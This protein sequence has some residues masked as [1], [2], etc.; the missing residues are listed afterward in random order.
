MLK[1]LEQSGFV[2]LD[3]AATSLTPQPVIDAMQRYYTEQRVTIHRGAYPQAREVAEAYEAVRSRTAAFIGASSASE[4][5]FT[6]SA[7]EALNL[8]AWG[9]AAQHVRSGDEIL[10]SVMEHHANFVPWQ[11]LAR[12]TGAVVNIVPLDPE[13]AGLDMN[14]LRALLSG[15]VRL[16]AVTG[17]SNVTGASPPLAEIADLVHDVGAV[18]VVDGT[19]M[20]AHQEVRLRDLNCDFL[21]FSGHKLCGPTGVGVLYGRSE[22][23]EAM[24]PLNYGG[25]MILSV[26]E[27][28]SVLLD[29]PRRFEGGTPNIAG[30]LGFGEA[31]EFLG[32]LGIHKIRMHESDLSERLLRACAASSSIEIINRDDSSS[33]G[34]ILSF[35]PRRDSPQELLGRLE[36]AG[37]MLRSGKLCAHPL[38]RSLGHSTVLRVSF[39]P[40]TSPQELAV[41]IDLV[42]A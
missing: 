14:A 1:K 31:L 12:R 3:S 38:I 35:V 29:P 32:S 18:L 16:V 28:R 22:L 6:K 7:T 39:G 15:N 30:V 23:L 5:V 11:Q 19:Q 20:V 4:I 27:K 42:G 33:P 2:Y 40:Y 9:W 8:V 36:Q 10:V 21:A 34:G 41:F 24:N 37:I 13:H 26:S 17:M 25:D